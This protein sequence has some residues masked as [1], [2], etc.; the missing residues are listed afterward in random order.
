MGFNG[1]PVTGIATPAQ[2]QILVTVPTGATT[3]LITMTNA[4]GAGSSAENFTISMAPIIEYF[5]PILGGPGTAV[6]IGGINLSNGF[7]VLQFGGVQAPF[8]VT[9]QNG[10][11]VRATVPTGAKSGPLTMTNAF[12]TFVTASNFFVTGSAPFVT[13]LAPAQGPRGTEVIITGGNFTSPATVRF[14]GV[15]DPTAAVTALTQIRAT[16]PAGALSG[17]VTVTTASGTNTNG[18]IFYVPPRL[19]SFTPAEAVVGAPVVLAGTNFTSAS[20]V[21]FSGLSADFE[22]T[23]SNRI[24]TVVPSGASSGP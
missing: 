14:N 1:K 13:E 5:D 23:A 4:S 16:V 19:T 9:G 20:Q 2:G 22:V 12:G 24:S 18:P 3:G 17:P 6:T 8:V 7:T 10:S 11:Q 15:T 21:L